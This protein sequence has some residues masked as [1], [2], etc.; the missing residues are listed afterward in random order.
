MGLFVQNTDFIGYKSIAQDKYTTERLNYYIDKFEKRYLVDLL[1][2]D[3]YDLFIADLDIDNLPTSPIYQT[4][5]NEICI[6]DDCDIHRS[7][8]IPEMLTCFIYWEFVKD[9]NFSNTVTGFVEASHE[10]GEGANLYKTNVT[11]IYNDAVESYYT[12]QWYIC[13]NENDYLEFNGQRKGKTS[14][15]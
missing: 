4:I 1:G 6:D 3:L 7:A 2:C 11:E 13:E 15:L 14:W 10:L 9:Q 12:I 5:F 8:G